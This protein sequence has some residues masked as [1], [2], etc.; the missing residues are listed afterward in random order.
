[1]KPLVLRAARFI[2]GEYGAIAG[3]TTLD[4]DI[5][6]DIGESYWWIVYDG[7][8][9][10]TFVHSRCAKVVY[11]TVGPFDCHGAAKRWLREN[12]PEVDCGSIPEVDYDKEVPDAEED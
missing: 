3:T 12:A 1:M 11:V 2:T 5:A 9:E 6:G 4:Q 7:K 10:I 8:D